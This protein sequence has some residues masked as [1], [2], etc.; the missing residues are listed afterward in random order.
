MYIQIFFFLGNTTY[1]NCSKMFQKNS[2]NYA[3]QRN[4]KYNW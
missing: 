1:D 3:K 4:N 2:K